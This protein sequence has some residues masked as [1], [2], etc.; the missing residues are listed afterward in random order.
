M[1]LNFNNNNNNKHL[2]TFY[3]FHRLCHVSFFSFKCALISMATCPCHDLLLLINQSMLNIVQFSFGSSCMVKACTIYKIYMYYI[4]T[5]YASR[6]TLKVTNNE[7][8]IHILIAV[9][10]PWSDHI[11]NIK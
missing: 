3:S 10:Y 2:F 8:Q 1:I 6:F 4:Y 7:L 5:S 9:V 11:C